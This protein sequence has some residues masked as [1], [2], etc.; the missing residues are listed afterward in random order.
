MSFYMSERSLQLKGVHCLIVLISSSSISK[1]RQNTFT[2]EVLSS[3]TSS[4][5]GMSA[6]SNLVAF[7][8]VWCSIP[9]MWLV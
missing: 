9:E 6:L 5:D 7:S 3:R 4:R 2:I 1:L 8:H